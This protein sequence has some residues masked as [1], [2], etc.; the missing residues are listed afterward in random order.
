MRH[1]YYDCQQVIEEESREETTSGL[2]TPS[3]V[4]ETNNL[5]Q[6]SEVRKLDL[7][8]VSND[9][10][11][12]S[13]KPSEATHSPILNMDGDSSQQQQRSQA[14]SFIINPSHSNRTIVTQQV[15]ANCSFQLL[16]NP[17]LAQSKVE[18][19]GETLHV[20][21]PQMYHRPVE[22][23]T[24]EDQM[25]PHSIQTNLKTYNMKSVD[26]LFAAAA[27]ASN[28]N[29]TSETLKV[30]SSFRASSPKKYQSKLKQ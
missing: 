3:R 14:H 7:G 29:V 19:T 30:E 28:L 9:N 24:I 15:S 22:V 8:S 11:T 5:S 23:V 10:R 21:H 27:D 20:L 26:N 17:E 18:S 4:N 6:F 2:Y 1:P 12:H 25:E 16:N 13:H